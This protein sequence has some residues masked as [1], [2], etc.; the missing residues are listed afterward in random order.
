MFS[1]LNNFCLSLWLASCVFS[2]HSLELTEFQPVSLTAP[3]HP[4]C[5]HPEFGALAPAAPTEVAA[6]ENLSAPGCACLPC[7]LESSV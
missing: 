4:F 2:A 1:G 7:H 3:S 6:G 5:H